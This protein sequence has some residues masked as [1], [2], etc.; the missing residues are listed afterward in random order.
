[1]LAR[2]ECQLVCIVV[3]I[4]RQFSAFSCLEVHIVGAFGV[5]ILFGQLVGLVQHSNLDTERLKCRLCPC[6]ALE[7]LPNLG[8]LLQALHLGRDVTKDA[9]RS[10]DFPLLLDVP[11]HVI[12]LHEVLD[13]VDGGVDAND[14]IADAECKPV[15]DLCTNGVHIV[16]RV[17][18]LKA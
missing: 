18:W 13:L 15:V 12:Q 9:V 11:H 3:S 8:A 4:C 2:F 6:N 5:A 16:S 17:V 14:L 7:D 1:M 10:R